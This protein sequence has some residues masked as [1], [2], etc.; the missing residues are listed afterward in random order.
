MNE[1]LINAR[2]SPLPPAIAGNG[3]SDF[4]V[5]WNDIGGVN[6]KGQIFGAD[7]TTGG[8]AFPINTTTEGTHFLPAAAMLSGFSPGFVV[9]WIAAGPAG[10]NVL[11]QRFDPN[12]TKR[13]GEIRVNSADVNTEHPPVIVRL[14]DLN[15]VVS[16]GSARLDEGIRARIFK[17]DGRTVG[18]EFGVNTSQGVHF[19]PIGTELDDGGFVIAWQGGP[20]FG[21]T[22]P[23][24]QTFQPD[25]SKSGSETAPNLSGF[26]DEMAI[27][28]LSAPPDSEP[29]HF[30]IAYIAGTG[31]EEKLLIASLFGPDGVLKNSTNITHN[32]DQSI[33][34]QVAMRALPNQRL[35]V[36]WTEKFVAHVGDRDEENVMAKILF[37]DSAAGVLL[38]S[39]KNIQVNA[40]PP[41]NQNRPCVATLLTDGGREVTAIAWIDDS[42]SGAGASSR[43]VKA[44]TFLGL[45]T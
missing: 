10:R 45:L 29:G 31:G 9:A 37:E 23:R 38:P 27:T 17:P 3:G 15:F 36:T 33:A 18:Q 8:S 24:F 1:V 14:T 11:A 32:D 6:L 5:V 41:G 25:G 21:R 35:V 2:T 7:G 43:A 16:W 22:F 20:S 34:S 42:V 40:P 26:H 39:T 4:V 13:G 30:A 44:R 12:G 28:F 19:A